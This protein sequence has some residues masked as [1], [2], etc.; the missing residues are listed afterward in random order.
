MLD[1]DKEIDK[2]IS[3][4][5]SVVPE[6]YKDHIREQ[7]MKVLAGTYNDTTLENKCNEIN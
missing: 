7:I 3:Y 5:I 2:Q 6:Q 1:N 4:V